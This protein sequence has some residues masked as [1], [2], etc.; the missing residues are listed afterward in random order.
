MK[1]HLL[2]VGEPKLSYAKEGWDE[3]YARLAHYH[4]LRVT[5]VSDKHA[6][7]APYI[8]NRAG[9]GYKIALEIEGT[10]FSSPELAQFLDQRAVL[11]QE[12]C[13]IVGGPE[14]LPEQVIQAANYRWSLSKLTLPHDLAMVVVLEA[15]YR[16]SSITAGH[17]YHK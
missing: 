9:D 13:F 5:R 4:Q 14:G 6:Y 11:G 12:L 8:L 17:P 2:T 16:A 15:L 7:D 1:L 3:Y 10:Q